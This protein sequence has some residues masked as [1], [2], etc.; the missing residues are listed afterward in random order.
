[1]NIKEIVAEYVEWIHMAQDRIQL[2]DPV[3]TV[4]NLVPQKTDNFITTRGTVSS[5]PW[6]LYIQIQCK[7]TRFLV[8]KLI[9]CEVV[10]VR[11]GPLNN[12]LKYS[13]GGVAS[14]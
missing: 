6:S 9:R 3:E 11:R 8:T 7:K 4:M 12:T 2:R 14:R 1:M 10:F 13:S 5:A